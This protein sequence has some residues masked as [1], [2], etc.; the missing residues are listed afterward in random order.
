MA[1]LDGVNIVQGSP[2]TV[3]NVTHGLGTTDIA[4]D[5]IIDNAGSDEKVIPL[6]VVS[7]DINNIQITF[8]A[9]QSGQVRVVGGGNA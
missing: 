6:S 9:A 7:V 2:A 8:S 1:I 4:V 3:W 5:V